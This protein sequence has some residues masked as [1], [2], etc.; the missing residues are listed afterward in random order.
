AASIG[1]VHRARTI[2]GRELALKIQYPGVARSI[3]SDIDNVVAVLRLVRLL[4]SRTDIDALAAEAARQMTQEA[5]YLAEAE[6]LSTFA[7][8]VAD[9][10]RLRVPRPHADLTTPRILAMD[11]MDGEPIEA[12]T[13]SSVRQST[14]DAI[15]ALL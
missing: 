5:D 2:D 12:L 3:R 10:P 14:R 7:A 11:F 4:P 13:A 8:L 9:E 1:Q 15:G 6:S